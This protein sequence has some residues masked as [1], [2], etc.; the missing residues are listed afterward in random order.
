MPKSKR[1]FASEVQS[2]QGRFQHEFG[3]IAWAKIM[4]AVSP[5]GKRRIVSECLASPVVWD[6]AGDTLLSS[7][8]QST[9]AGPPLIWKEGDGKEAEENIKQH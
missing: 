8:M 6:M 5:G 7:S 9:V 3:D 2:S 1:E 4:V